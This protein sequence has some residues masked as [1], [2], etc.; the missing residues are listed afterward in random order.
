[1]YARNEGYTHDLTTGDPSA[2]DV[3][4]N[5]DQITDMDD[6]ELTDSAS[7]NGISNVMAAAQDD[8]DDDEYDDDEYEDDGE[9]GDDQPKAKL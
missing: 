7:S 3:A 1:M 5:W 9:D 8:D 2:E 6:I 4:A